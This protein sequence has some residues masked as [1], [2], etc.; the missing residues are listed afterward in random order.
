MGIGNQVKTVLLLG[1]LAGLMLVIG[2][3]VGG[4][5][6]LFIALTISI[7]INFITYWFSDKIV[8]FM[9]K[10][11]E[12][13]KKHHAQLHSIVESV[14][15]KANIPKPKVYII[16]NETPNA[17]ATGRGPSNAAVACTTGIMKLLNKEE[18]EGVIAHEMAHVKNRDILV[19][20]I[21]A[22]I[23]SIISYVASMA[24]W[25]AY[26]GND[27]D[28]ANFLAVIILSI[29]APIIAIIIQLAIS[30]SRE[31]LADET[32]AK[33][34]KNPKGLA[35]ALS[36]LSNGCAAKPMKSANQAT[37]SLFIVNPFSAK[38]VFSLFSTHPPIDERIR[39]LNQMKV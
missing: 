8:L 9:Y 2:F 3:L 36:K 39:R 18:L 26:F 32:G 4:R 27:D 22:T 16:E 20:T 31:Y 38:A 24:R 17:F 5:Q 1:S 34:V 14:A 13:D 15:K 23:A 35:S 33:I 12:A 25:G 21:A 11:K 30:R 29:L 10:A 28:G 37:A 6:G 19:A 7:L